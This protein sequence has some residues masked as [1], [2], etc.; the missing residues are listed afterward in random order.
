MTRLPLSGWTEILVPAGRR[1]GACAEKVIFGRLFMVVGSLKA[2]WEILGS[3]SWFLL[4]TVRGREP[5]G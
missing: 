4:I 3:L 1:F 5:A 2:T